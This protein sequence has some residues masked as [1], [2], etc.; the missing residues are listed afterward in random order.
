MT[1]PRTLLVMAGGTGGHVFPGL[2]VAQALR[3][4][5]WNIVWL[6]NRTGMEA[7]LVP[8]HGIPMEYI[9][10]GG[11]RGKGLLTK[12]LLPLNLLRAFWQS[13]G[14]LRRVRPNVVLG[15]GGYITFPAGMMASL[16]GRPLVLHEQNSIAGLANKVL[17]KVA[18]RVL[19]AFPDTLPGGEWTGNPVREELAHLDAPEARYGQ[20]TGPL[21]ILV[22]GGSLGA[23]ALNEVVPKAI[24]LL[25]QSERPVVTHQAGARQIDTLRANYAAAQVPAQT[26]PF[27]D[28]MARAY[29]D[30]DLVIC[31]AGAMTVSE[32]AA[33]GVAALFVPFPHAVDDHQTTNAKFL[34][35]QGAALLVQQQDLTAEGLAQTIASLT[36]PQLK[37]M[38]RMA[39]G[40]AKPEATRRVAEVCSQLARD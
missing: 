11:L 21:R 26:L 36:R 16:L 18:D 6:G 13:I 14:A 34:S 22:V 39:R 15:M 7:T 27:I 8:K 33:A 37:D 12:L 40:L 24:A 5:G 29:A 1:A 23:A 20:R 25:P 31:R 32:V 17:A 19:C 35:S 9:Q 3:E 4:Q 28:D 30:A 2:A 38:A 10:F